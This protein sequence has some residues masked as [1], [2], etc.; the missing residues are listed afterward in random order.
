M[1]FGRKL[2]LLMFKLKTFLW[3][4]LTMIKF[5]NCNLQN[6]KNVNK[7]NWKTIRNFLKGFVTDLNLPS[8]QIFFCLFGETHQKSLKALRLI[9]SSS[10]MWFYPLSRRFNLLFEVFL[11]NGHS[12]VNLSNLSTRRTFAIFGKFEYSPKWTFWKIV[13]TC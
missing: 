1:W 11:S 13:R 10:K 12:T 5:K 4:L 2:F 9:M 3:Q 6:C 7:A 8:K